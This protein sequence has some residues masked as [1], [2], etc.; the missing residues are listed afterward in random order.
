MLLGWQTS[1]RTHDGSTPTPSCCCKTADSVR[2]IKRLLLVGAGADDVDNFGRIAADMR[3]SIQTIEALGGTLES[4]ASQST[5]A[6]SSSDLKH[7]TRTEFGGW[8]S[9]SISAALGAYAQR[10]HDRICN[11]DVVDASDMSPNHFAREY[12]SRRE[13]VLVK[14]AVSSWQHSGAWTRSNL[15]ALMSS[16]SV[17]LAAGAV[18]YANHYGIPERPTSITR[19]LAALD[20]FE[21]R[22]RLH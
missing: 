19:Y 14:N 8:S 10:Q 6:V 18:P 16:S 17:Q 22:L 3:S 2:V 7:P 11:F 5:S 9:T 20:E 15:T 21:P 1:A 12:L 4:P 13:P